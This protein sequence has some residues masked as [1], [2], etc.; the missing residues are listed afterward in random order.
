M[1][2]GALTSLPTA[3]SSANHRPDSILAPSPPLSFHPKTRELVPLTFLTPPPPLGAIVVAMSSTGLAII[4][5]SRFLLNS[6]NSTSSSRGGAISC[7]TAASCNLFSVYLLNNS[8]STHGSAGGWTLGSA[9]YT[10]VRF[11]IEGSVVSGNVVTGVNTGYTPEAYTDAAVYGSEV[12]GS[13]K[14]TSFLYNTAYL[15]TGA[16]GTVSRRLYHSHRASMRVGFLR[17]GL[18]RKPFGR[19]RPNALAPRRCQ[20]S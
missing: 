20:R 12:S 11:R 18:G 6:A 9:L 16:F 5:S 4:S 19:L 7:S 17:E 15:G 13:V 3:S 14:S 2:L 8:A 10:G 1:A